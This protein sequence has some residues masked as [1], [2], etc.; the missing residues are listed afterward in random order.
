MVVWQQSAGLGNVF[1]TIQSGTRSLVSV[2]ALQTLVPALQGRDFTRIYLVAESVAAGRDTRSGLRQGNVRRWG[3]G[4]LVLRDRPSPTVLSVTSPTALTVTQTPG[5]STSSLPQMISGTWTKSPRRHA[6]SILKVGIPTNI[7]TK[8]EIFLYRKVQEKDKYKES[9]YQTVS[10]SRVQ[11][12]ARKLPCSI[13]WKI[14]V[15][16][17]C[18]I[19]N[20]FIS[21]IHCHLKS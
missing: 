16:W 18:P 15:R 7:T 21:W 3:G 12:L 17:Y 5:Y 10:I 14:Y 1:P 11:I 19:I 2:T 13:T 9:R 8:Y 4:D 6:S 20:W